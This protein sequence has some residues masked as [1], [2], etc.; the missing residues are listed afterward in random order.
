NGAT[1]NVLSG[2]GSGSPNK[3]LRTPSGA[4]APPPPP[5]AP[6][7]ASFTVSC[8]GATCSFNASAS[9]DDIGVVNYAWNFGDGST[10]NSASTSASRTY[11]ASGTYTVTLT[12][13]DAS[14]QTN[15]TTRTATA[16]VPVNAAPVANFTW[17]CAGLTC[18]LDG[19]SS[20]DDGQI[21][22]Y[23]WNLGKSP[24]GTASGSLI[25]V[26]YPHD[27]NRTVTLTV[28]DNGGK[29]SSITKII[30]IGG[31]EPPPPA[32]A[33]P[34]AS[35]TVSCSNLACS[36]NASA[37]SDDK[38]VVNYSW[39]FGDGGSASGASSTASRT[40]AAGGT[41]TVTLTVSDVAGQ[42]ST[43]PRTVTVSAAVNQAPVA[44]FTVSCSG[45]VCAL[46]ARASTDDGQIVSYAWNLGKSPGGTGSG[47]TLSVA[48]P[49]AGPR[50][51]VLTVTDN[52]GKTSSVSKTFEV[53]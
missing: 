17:S 46:D 47:A 2:L 10:S 19:R 21:S 25:S 4:A 18:T 41:Y 52:A 27:G 8:S 49:H 51:V 15:S 6:P 9:I 14:N 7:T 36:M 37:S 1:S 48:Y 31:T 24:G 50:T 30:T 12:V 28:V 23:N 22:Q 42:T 13:S 39:N 32:D 26:T 45:W 44:S 20:T 16:N 3:L 40:Y 53:Q 29:S 38:G 11:A 5:N 33:P 35:F 34:V 43:T